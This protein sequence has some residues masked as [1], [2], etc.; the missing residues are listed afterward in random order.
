[1]I[2]TYDIIR[3]GDTSYSKSIVYGL[4]FVTPLSAI[5]SQEKLLDSIIY[6]AVYQ[7]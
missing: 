7:L 6:L 4:N 2:T 3:V 1:M 5:K